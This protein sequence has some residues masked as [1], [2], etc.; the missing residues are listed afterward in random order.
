MSLTKLSCGSRACTLSVL[1]APPAL[2]SGEEKASGKNRKR[3]NDVFQQCQVDDEQ[4]TKTHTTAWGPCMAVRH[5][6]GAHALVLEQQR[7]QRLQ[8]WWPVRS[9]RAAPC[10]VLMEIVI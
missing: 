9:S 5:W 2:P 4:P 7:E 6:A 10:P 3:N 8:R 1:S